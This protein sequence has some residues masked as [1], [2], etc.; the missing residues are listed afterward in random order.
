MGALFE[1]YKRAFAA[2]GPIL[3]RHVFLLVNGVIFAVVALLFL[4]GEK[5]AAIFLGIIIVFN[6][7]LGVIQDFRA[8]VALE[9]L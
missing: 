2:S 6:I 8:R 1:P 3:V 4:F 7:F 5:E 9:R